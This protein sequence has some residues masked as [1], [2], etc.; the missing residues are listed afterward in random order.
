MQSNISLNTNIHTSHLIHGIREQIKIPALPQEAAGSPRL[1][2]SIIS[3]FFQ[4]VYFDPGKRENSFF[5]I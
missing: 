2:T 5:Q 4:N 3:K 1:L